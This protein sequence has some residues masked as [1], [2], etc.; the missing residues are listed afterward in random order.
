[1]SEPSASNVPV[2]KFTAQDSLTK[3]RADVASLERAVSRIS[4]NVEG[5]TQVNFEFTQQI[6]DQL[7]MIQDLT[8]H[9]EGNE[10]Y[11]ASIRST[12]E[13]VAAEVER[14]NEKFTFID[15]E[16]AGIG[17]ATGTNTNWY[18]PTAP[19]A[20]DGVVEGDLWFTPENTIKKFQSGTWVD[21]TLSGSVL[22]ELAATKIVGEI[23]AAQIASG[24]VSGDQL[25]QAIKDEIAQA[26]AD[27]T[28][29]LT[30]AS[31][32]LALATSK[33]KVI[34]SGDNPPLTGTYQ[35]GDMW[36]KVAGPQPLLTD[37]GFELGN[38][39]FFY[40]ESGV[41]RD[42]T[43]PA[44]GGVAS[45]RWTSTGVNQDTGES[46]WKATNLVAGHTYRLVF[47]T[48]TPTAELKVASDRPLN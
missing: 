37:S 35:E 43:H 1:M 48:K 23:T 31:A 38:G 9:I 42:T 29:G 6:T 18:T 4:T 30:G 25:A 33:S 13:A 3:L 11:A 27:A 8:Q 12:M 20:E 26:Q 14:V 36:V 28:E 34:R 41:A 2:I 47:W 21:I 46:F 15:G 16:L 5:H 24:A 45:M 17:S 40:M 39:P 10:E 19:T 22:T 7:R 32:A 44:H